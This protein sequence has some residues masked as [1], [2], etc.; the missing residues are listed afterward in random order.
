[1]SG[2]MLG[3]SNDVRLHETGCAK[4]TARR[5][6]A[7]RRY[8]YDRPDSS[9]FTGSGTMNLDSRLAANYRLTN[10]HTRKSENLIISESNYPVL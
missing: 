9:I 10:R 5:S 4:Y 7:K 8:T 1:V 3:L 6:S 2:G